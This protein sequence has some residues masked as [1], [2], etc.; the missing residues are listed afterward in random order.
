MNLDTDGRKR[1]K[2]DFFQNKK[3]ET[4]GPG[5][6]ATSVHHVLA[7]ALTTI[8]PAAAAVHCMCT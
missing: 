2:W 8:E 3:R 6:F 5:L 4:K 1:A 7:A